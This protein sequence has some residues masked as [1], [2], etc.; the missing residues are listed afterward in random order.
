[1]ANCT[2][3]R[4]R[5]CSRRLRPTACC[6]DA[7][8]EFQTFP[9]GFRPYR[10]NPVFSHFSSF[11]QVFLSFRRT[12]RESFEFQTQICLTSLF[13]LG[14]RPPARV[15]GLMLSVPNR[16]PGVQFCHLWG[17]LVSRGWRHLF[18]AN[19]FGTFASTWID[20]LRTRSCGARSLRP[21]GFAGPRTS[22]HRPGPP[23]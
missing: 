11:R 20:C 15:S 16:Q 23:S 9:L 10:R 22:F 12:H 8:F 7:S 3:A 14:F 18:E 4:I 21:A 6:A 17:W 1:M 19:A 5:S 13:L 2:G